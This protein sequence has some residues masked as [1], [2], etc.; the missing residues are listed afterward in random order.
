MS[1]EGTTVVVTG[2]GR[3]LGRAFA[4]GLADAGANVVLA[5]IADTSEA[6]GEIEESGGSVLPLRVDI[7]DQS[8]LKAMVRDAT[9]RFGGVDV[10]I[11][12]A[13][14]FRAAR[15]GSFEDVDLDEL[16]RCL[17]VNVK[18][19][20]LATRAVLPLMKAAGHGK[21]INVSSASIWKGTSATG[22]HY[23]TSKSAL[24]GF[25]RALARELGPHGITVNNLVPDA[26]PET[27]LSSDGSSGSLSRQID[28]RCLKREQKA[29]DM[30]GTVL[31]LSGSGSD[32]VTG[33]SLHVNGGSFFS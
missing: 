14:Y 17:E 4:R 9:D 24:I 20:W 25:T 16:D 27:G 21:I 30:V 15:S 8:S 2:G 3:G 6:V 19:T 7:T 5:D 12:N 33:Q 22:P 18:G 28:Q 32:F 11:N 13:A 23:L 26:I 31:Y 29:Q 10:L 1:V